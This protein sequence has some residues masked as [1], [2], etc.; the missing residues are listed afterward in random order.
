MS[1]NYLK[2]CISKTKHCGNKTMEIALTGVC[3]DRISIC[4]M[5]A[6]RIVTVLVGFVIAVVVMKSLRCAFSGCLI[7][8]RL[9]EASGP[10]VN[11]FII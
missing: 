9:A 2:M 4:K 11:T 10:H 8:K 1:I 6:F 3:I 5:I 7:I